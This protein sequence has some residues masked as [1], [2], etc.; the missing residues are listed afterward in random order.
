MIVLGVL[1]ADE[2]ASAEAPGKAEKVDLLF[3]QN[4]NGASVDLKTHTLTLLGVSQT[5]IFFSDRPVRIAR[6]VHDGR[7][8]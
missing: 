2:I 3:V 4:A 7:G 5:T 8:P 6:T 1:P